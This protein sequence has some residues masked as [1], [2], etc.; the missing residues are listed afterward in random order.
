MTIA[1]RIEVFRE[2]DSSSASGGVGRASDP[3]ELRM[4]ESIG[5][6]SK[7]FQTLTAKGNRERKD[8]CWKRFVQ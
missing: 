4:Y 6:W 1:P 5:K 8:N 7:V 2:F 3:T